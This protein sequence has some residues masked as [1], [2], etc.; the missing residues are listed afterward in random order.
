MHT[1]STL[2]I[3]EHRYSG[4][5]RFLFRVLLE[6]TDAEDRR[7]D[8]LPRGHSA[9]LTEPRRGSLHSSTTIA[10]NYCSVLSLILI[11]LYHYR[12]PMNHGLP[13]FDHPALMA[14]RDYNTR[15]LANVYAFRSAR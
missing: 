3:A 4:V 11:S 12:Y 14:H 13:T 5:H 15:D 9:N 10:C 8:H 1:E 7:D 2:A 6:N